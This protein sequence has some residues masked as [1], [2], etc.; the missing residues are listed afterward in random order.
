MAGRQRVHAGWGWA[1]AALAAALLFVLLTQQALAARVGG[2]IA[3]V[4]ISVMS[5]V[6]RLVAAIFGHH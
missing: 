4:W 2:A 1:A 3:G 6:L 5:V